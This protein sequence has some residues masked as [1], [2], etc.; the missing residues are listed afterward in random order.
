MKNISRNYALIHNLVEVAKWHRK[1][2]HSPCN[3]SLQL[4]R[5]A[6][7]QLRANIWKDEDSEVMKEIN[8]TDWS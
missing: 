8:E 1:N 2:C 6:C 5:E 7:M 3:V 4:I